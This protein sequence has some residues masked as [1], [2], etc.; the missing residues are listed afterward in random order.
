VVTEEDDGG[1]HVLIN[2]SSVDPD[3]PHDGTCI[4]EPGEH[5]FIKQKSY[6]AYEFAI[7]RHKNFIADKIKRGIYI[8]RKNA[9]PELVSKICDGIKKSAFTKRGIKDG[10]DK[11]V[12]SVQKRTAKKS[13][14][15]R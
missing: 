7:E 11:A 10:Y 8:P 6:A 5:E 9:A 13:A 2:V 3:V 4:L 14:E 1:M 15:D 12:R